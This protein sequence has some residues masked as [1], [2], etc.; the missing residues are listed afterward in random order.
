MSFAVRHEVVGRA[1]ASRRLRL[2]HVSDLHLWRGGAKLA[3]LDEALA[4]WRPEVVVLTGDYADTPWGRH[5]ARAWIEET[6]RR[7]PVC[8]I[9]GNHDHWW[10]GGFVRQLRAIR[11]AHAIDHADARITAADGATVRFTR[12][13]GLVAAG[14]AG[15]TVVLLHDPAAIQPELL[16]ARR[17]CLVLAGHLHGG[18][19]TLWHDRR[20]QPQPAG[21]FYGWLGTRAEIGAT[22][23]IVSRGL[24]DTLPL[25]LRVP[26]EL[27]IVDWRA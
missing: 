13:T 22:T 12:W 1:H 9:A 3:R 18:Q 27:V 11:R 23:V 2:A 24:G 25:R 20:G 14:A 15:P 17:D 6:A 21:L 19:I 10:G 8:W 16:H 26:R 7:L 5:A 4:T